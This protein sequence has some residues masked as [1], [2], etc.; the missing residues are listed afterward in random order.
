M[1]Q[2][3]EVGKQSSAIISKLGDLAIV[4]EA[5]NVAVHLLE[6]GACDVQGAKCCVEVKAG[7]PTEPD[8]S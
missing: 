7:R 2:P 6:W 4:G 5:L 8:L 1:T 3:P